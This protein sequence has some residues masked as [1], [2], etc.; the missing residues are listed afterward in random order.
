MNVGHVWNIV[1]GWEEGEKKY[2]SIQRKHEVDFENTDFGRLQGKLAWIGKQ[3]TGFEVSDK[4]CEGR[5]GDL[6]IE[7]SNIVNQ[8]FSQETIPNSWESWSD[9]IQL[10]VLEKK[11]RIFMKSVSLS[12]YD[13][14]WFYH[15][16]MQLSQKKNV[17]PLSSILQC[18]QTGTDQPTATE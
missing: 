1:V 10:S 2:I 17:Y 7:W 4:Q 3:K 13:L 15:Y 11:T 14:L 6:K 5:Q 12:H 18:R 8:E 9:A 16:I